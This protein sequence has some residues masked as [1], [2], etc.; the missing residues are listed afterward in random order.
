MITEQQICRVHT[1]DMMVHYIYY[2]KF[3][4][5]FVELAS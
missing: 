2:V 3:S 1:M 5:E 4:W